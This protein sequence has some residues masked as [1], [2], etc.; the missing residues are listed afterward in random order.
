[1]TKMKRT[2]LYKN[3]RE[4]KWLGVCAGLADYFGVEVSFVRVGFVLGVI[5]FSPVVLLGYILM[6]IILNEEPEG[7]YADEKEEEFWREARRDPEYSAA[8]LR[9]RFR[10]IEART[11][12]MEA[13]MTS[14]RFRLD[15]EIKNL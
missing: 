1:M 8:E 10:D 3:R 6:G 15:R 4:G 11:R 9:R 14:K 5:L 2:A 7:L 12:D 13:Y